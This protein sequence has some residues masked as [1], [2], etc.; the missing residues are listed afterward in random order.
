MST[1]P[2]SLLSREFEITF[3][4]VYIRVGKRVVHGSSE[5]SR[6]RGM[7]SSLVLGSA[8]ALNNELGFN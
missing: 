5:I 7:F 2:D 1:S 4:E 3:A 8:A 6:L